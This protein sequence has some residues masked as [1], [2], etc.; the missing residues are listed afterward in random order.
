VREGLAAVGGVIDL[1][2]RA[3]AGTTVE[4]RLPLTLAILPVLVVR[5]GA[6]RYAIPQSAVIEV[7]RVPEGGHERVA[8][9]EVGRRRG[10]L[11]PVVALG[12]ALAVPD[13]DPRGGHLVVVH[14][15]AHTF[16]L[17]VDAVADTQ[18]VV[19]RPLDVAHRAL[20][21]FAGATVLGDGGIA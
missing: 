19:V 6:E 7:A 4:L 1:R 15:G 13:A 20:T 8:G 9:A 21:V 16:G 17:R 12:D 18:E 3:G 14:T 11:L 5:S 2:T 10:Q